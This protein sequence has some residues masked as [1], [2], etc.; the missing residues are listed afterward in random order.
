MTKFF[1]I[2]H[3][4]DNRTL[5]D[6]LSRRLAMDKSKT[7]ALLDAFDTIVAERCSEL[8]SIAIPGFGTFEPRKKMERVAV[9]PSTGKRMLIP[10]K[11]T[12]SFRPSALL[13]QKI[14]NV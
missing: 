8:D 3:I 11:I 1:V 9:H 13:K 12:L 10:P 5:I 7:A 6:T 4:M 14:K 2:S